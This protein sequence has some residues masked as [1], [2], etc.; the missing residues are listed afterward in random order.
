MTPALVI[1][2]IRVLF[3]LGLVG[4]K[5]AQGD[6]ETSKT[7]SEHMVGA[8][9]YDFW[10]AGAEGLARFIQK[11]DSENL[12][13]DLQ[14]AVRKAQLSATLLAVGASLAEAQ[15]IKTGKVR[16]WLEP[17]AQCK[18]EDV[19]WLRALAKDLQV[20]IRRL[21][22]EISPTFI[23]ES[24]IATLLTRKGVSPENLNQVIE[25]ATEDILQEIYVGG[26]YG[27]P[28]AESA[29]HIVEIAVRNGW[30]ISYNKHSRSTQHS[31]RQ[32]NISSKECN[33]FS[34]ICD[35]FN[36]EYKTNPRVTAAVQKYLLLD[37][38][39]PQ[40]DSVGT[41][42]GRDIALFSKHLD[43]FCDSFARLRVLLET[44]DDIQNEILAFLKDS[45]EENR[46]LHTTTHQ[47]LAEI[48][49]VLGSIGLSLQA[50]SLPSII[51]TITT[52]ETDTE[53]THLRRIKLYAETMGKGLSVLDH[54]ELQMEMK[55]HCDSEAKPLTTLLEKYHRLILTGGRG[56]GKTI[57]MKQTLRSLCRSLIKEATSRSANKRFLVPVYVEL[58]QLSSEL[59][60]VPY[61]EGDLIRLLLNNL[62]YF[63]QA[64]PQRTF[65]EL[66]DTYNM[67]LLLDGLNELPP[68]DQAGCRTELFKL[69][70]GLSSGRSE[71]LRI[72]VSSRILGFAKHSDFRE[73]GWETAELLALD[74]R[75]I[76][77]AL[78]TSLGLRLGTTVF[79][80]LDPKFRQIIATPQ[81]L[82]HFISLCQHR[83]EE[84]H[85]KELSDE[86]I[87]EDIVR[88]KGLLL[89]H[90]V[91]MAMRRL[92]EQ[93]LPFVEAILNQL[94]YASVRIGTSFPYSRLELIDS[95]GTQSPRPIALNI[96]HTIL[97][98]ANSKI[99]AEELV[100][101]I[102]KSGIL[103]ILKSRNLCRFE[104][105]SFQEYFAACRMQTLWKLDE[106]LSDSRWREP[107]A[108]MAGLLKHRHLD[109]LLA[110]A[111]H[112][113]ELY[114][115]LL[116][117][118]HEPEIEAAFQRK[119]I[120]EFEETTYRWA[121][122]IAR[123]LRLLFIV[124]FLSVPALAYF[125]SQLAG[126]SP[127][128]QILF[129]VGALGYFFGFPLVLIRW[130]DRQFRHRQQKLKMRELPKLVNIMR[131]LQAR[132]AM[133]LVLQELL[134]LDQELQKKEFN[135]DDPRRA[136]IREARIQ[137]EN[138]VLNPSYMTEDEMMEHLSDPLVAASIDLGVLS[139]R[140]IESLYE[141]A[142]NPGD[143]PSGF[144]AMEKLRELW[145]K[146][147][148]CRE[149]VEEVLRTV[150]LNQAKDYSRK[151]QQYAK[152][153][154]RELGIATRQATSER[155]GIV[156]RFISWIK[157]FLFSRA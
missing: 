120:E 94:A 16:L 140:G 139:M 71:R 49:Q 111:E 136:F 84:G 1:A 117:H 107:L 99:D 22:Q 145:G 14:L 51:Q 124:W 43:R 47:K 19:K 138:A 70:Q 115:Y 27:E 67:I 93:H 155:V 68:D 127:R 29:Y 90:Q 72:V 100:E 129:S 132:P 104:H 146:D 61:R 8:A 109:E 50:I 38:H 153:Y 24:Q 60:H 52:K 46:R 56:I 33:W 5:V 108:I 59:T 13:Q 113:P 34:L 133:K 114:A 39:V 37:I 12:K 125:V 9:A 157:S 66:L 81:N 23:E 122:K 105:H 11:G 95:S 126:S 35:F 119:R 134:S 40:K 128:I 44:R 85:R 7:V 79:R 89:K 82:D 131:I 98:D 75:Q 6:I 53:I 78:S 147:P 76:E 10:K 135:E 137:V 55:A 65:V 31:L 116:A 3:G 36:E 96:T 130:N 77:A 123:S 73:R 30:K 103:V 86:H 121:T 58:G 110:R 88:Q 74:L 112:D 42:D 97:Q 151:R 28:F 17:Q 64:E 20:K 154:C 141:K 62:G 45:I 83:F 54:L 143:D 63:S 101:G 41:R 150:A 2:S 148:E 156:A 15:R 152:T 106:Y 57:F 149:R 48:E 32:T 144:K 26:P 91:T 80:K 142:L 102:S 4:Y 18:K 118:V 92:D 87:V 21:S 69:D 25:K